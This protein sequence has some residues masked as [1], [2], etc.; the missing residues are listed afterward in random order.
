MVVL[1]P[2][3]RKT[4]QGFLCITQMLNISTFG[5]T[6]DIYVI[7][8]RT[9]FLLIPKHK[10]TAHVYWK[11]YLLLSPSGK[12]GK[13][14]AGFPLKKWRVSL[15]IGVRITMIRCAVY[16]L[17]IFKMFHILMNNPVLCRHKL[18]RKRGF[19][20]TFMLWRDNTNTQIEFV[21]ITI[22]WVIIKVCI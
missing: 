3:E 1:T 15:Y 6:A 19:K 11:P 22:F 5:N 13:L 12:L 16:L 8:Q 2:I 18:K 20:W 9:R 14:C 7:V 10:M 4:L 17:R 21:D